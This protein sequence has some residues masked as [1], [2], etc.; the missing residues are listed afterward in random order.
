MN[1][2]HLFFLKKANKI[3]S[4]SKDLSTKVGAFIV[5]EDELSPLGFGYNGLPRGFPDN[6]PIKNERPE[7]YLWTEHAERNA[8]YNFAQQLM[9]NS[10]IFLSHFPNMDST[11]A[12]VSCGIQSIILPSL[13]N[14][15]EHFSRV[16]EM[17][18]HAKVDLIT[19]DSKTSHILKENI[20]QK[21]LDKYRSYLELTIE[22]GE[23]LSDSHSVKKEGALIMKKKTLAP[24]SMGA[25]GP[26]PNLKID[27]KR[28]EKE[29]TSFWLQD[30]AKNAI[31]NAVRP[32]LKNS[33]AYV[34][35]CPC[36]HCALALSSVG[37]KKVVTFQPDFTQ[38]ADVRWK[39]SFTKA[40]EIFKNVN[41]DMDLVE[42]DMVNDVVKI[43]RGLK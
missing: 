14:E 27:S 40:A 16:I 32:K 34:S 11:R 3:A 17:L 41:I 28:I 13:N 12:I 38:E 22:Y 37:I 9:D 6:D 23:D 1:N 30:A 29:G 8:I 2:K 24:I 18:T 42:K 43:K 25:E 21:T 35:W 36:G 26:P 39:E 33:T 15:H 7:K 20:T 31:F 19:L 5:D 4:N 10:I